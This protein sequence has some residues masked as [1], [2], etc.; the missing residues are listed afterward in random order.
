VALAQFGH[1]IVSS[2]EI[3]D[4]MGATK[5]KFNFTNLTVTHTDTRSH[6]QVSVLIIMYPPLLGTHCRV[7]LLSLQ[8]TSHDTFE[9]NEQFSGNFRAFY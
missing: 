8:S 3:E 2:L 4:Q 1:D 5:N 9:V 6:I 7:L